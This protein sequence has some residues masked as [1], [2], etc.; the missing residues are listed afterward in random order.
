MQPPAR[1]TLIE[2]VHTG[3]ENSVYR[4][5]RESDGL[6]VIVKTPNSPYP[7]RSQLARLSHEYAMLRRAGGRGAVVP[8]ELSQGGELIALVTEDWD[9][10]PLHHLL[11]PGPLPLPEALAVGVQIAD[12]LA[13]LHTSGVLHKDVKPQ[14]IPTE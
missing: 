3:I 12:A 6:R 2:R 4:G 13:A 1:Y 11:A 14:T 5:V 9:G 10:T 8:L 7:S